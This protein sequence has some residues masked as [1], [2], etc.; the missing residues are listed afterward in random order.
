[1]EPIPARIAAPLQ[2][3][4]AKVS[5]AKHGEEDR[6]APAIGD[7][8][9][10]LVDC[11]EAERRRLSA[12]AEKKDEVVLLLSHQYGPFVLKQVCG[13]CRYTSKR[14]MTSV[15]K[16]I[17]AVLVAQFMCSLIS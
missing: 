12:Q 16:E 2:K 9:W 14:I 3:H 5:A 8:D 13:P 7:L 17:C 6:T 1:M 4:L 15:F 11:T 10:A